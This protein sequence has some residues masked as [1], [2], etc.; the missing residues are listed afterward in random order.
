MFPSGNR[1]LYFALLSSCLL[2][3]VSSSSTTSGSSAGIFLSTFV[4]CLF[5]FCVFCCCCDRGNG[6]KHKSPKT[7]LDETKPSK[8]ESKFEHADMSL[9]K[10]IES[11]DQEIRTLK[12]AVKCR[13]EQIDI[14]ESCSLSVNHD[15]FVTSH[16]AKWHL[17]RH[18]SHVQGAVAFK[19]LGA[20]KHCV[21]TKPK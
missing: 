14:L 3:L 16:G 12:T 15:A 17:S 8:Y 18:C 10:I 11:Q 5:C 7:L 20:C 9:V 4:T 1:L 19:T 6:K 21:Q 13:D 2:P